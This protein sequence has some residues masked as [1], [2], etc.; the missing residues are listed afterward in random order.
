MKCHCI[1][2]KTKEVSSELFGP[3]VFACQYIHMHSKNLQLGFIQVWALHTKRD[4]DKMEH[5]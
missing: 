3:D 1:L 4:L 2:N 5:T